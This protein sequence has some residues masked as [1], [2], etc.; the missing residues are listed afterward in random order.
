MWP[1]K[2]MRDGFPTAPMTDMTPPLR[3]FSPGLTIVVYLPVSRERCL[4]TTST[5]TLR[6]RAVA[7]APRLI[8]P[9]ACANVTRFNVRR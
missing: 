1:F 5:V 3:T 6:F 4:A 9:L 7:V 8:A 2:T